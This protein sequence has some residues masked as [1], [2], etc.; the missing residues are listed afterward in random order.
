MIKPSQ[1]PRLIESYGNGITTY[2][3]DGNKAR[4]LRAQRSRQ[5]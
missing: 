5:P 4:S 1:R 3:R 2:V